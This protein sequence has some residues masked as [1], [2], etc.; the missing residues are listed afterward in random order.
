MKIVITT[1]QVPFVTGGAESHALNLRNALTERG[2]EAEIVTMPCIFTPIEEIEDN[3][4]VSRLL[5]ITNTWGHPVDLCIGLKFPAYYMKH[6]NKVLWILHQHRSAYELFDTPYSDIG[7]NP[8]GRSVRSIIYRADNVYLSEAKK[9]Y[10]NSRNVSSRLMKYNGID[11]T[12]LYHPCP[13][14]ES[15]Q[16]GEYGDYILM[17]SRINVTKRQFLAIEAMAMTKSD[18]KLC[19]VGRAESDTLYHKMMDMI[20]RLNLS[21]R[22]IYKNFVSQEEKLSL[23]A[24]ARAVLFIPFDEDYG[25]ISLEAMSAGKALI[26]AS[27]SGGPLEFVVPGKTGLIAAPTPSGVAKAMDVLGESESEARRMGTAARQYLDSL[28][29]TWDNVV[30]KLVNV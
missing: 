18:I 23:Y 11:S 8:A 26:T 19:I 6:P 29:I 4:V 13:D 28:E 10:A 30:E 25:Y 15:F 20:K 16:I 1:V 21:K 12:P 5:N 22:V 14:M 17:P 27:D 24:N 2:H 3:I 9:I 7:D